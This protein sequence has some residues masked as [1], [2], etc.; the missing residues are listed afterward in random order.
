MTKVVAMVAEAVLTVYVMYCLSSFGITTQLSETYYKLGKL[1]WLFQALLVFIGFVVFPVWLENSSEGTM[2]LA[3]LSVVSLF[4]VATNPLY[5]SE[6]RKQHTIA[7][8]AA[9]IMTVLWMLFNGYVLN[10]VIATLTTIALI[11]I[12]PSSWVYWGELAVLYTLLSTLT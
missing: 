3:F 5:L 6:Q 8:V 2:F 11:L 9:F 10:V 1:G 12:K 4:I 7:A